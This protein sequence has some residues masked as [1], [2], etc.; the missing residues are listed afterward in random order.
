MQADRATL[1]M[2]I[3]GPHIMLFTV[4]Y[5]PVGANEYGS[6]LSTLCHGAIGENN[7]YV[8]DFERVDLKRKVE[9]QPSVQWLLHPSEKKKS[10]IALTGN[11][12][13]CT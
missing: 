12:A 11:N 10:I 2:S 9:V 8:H 4:S 13:L 7:C 5:S 1:S 6:G 3:M